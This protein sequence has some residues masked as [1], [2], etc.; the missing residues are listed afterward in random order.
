MRLLDRDIVAATILFG[1]YDR[2]MRACLSEN[3]PGDRVFQAA[4]VYGRF[5]RKLGERVGPTGTST[6]STWCPSRPRSAAG[7]CRA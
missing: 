3:I 4:H 6:W 5:I 1:N 2:L 7:S